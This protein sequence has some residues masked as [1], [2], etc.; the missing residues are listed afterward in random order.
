[1]DKRLRL[2]D[3]YRGLDSDPA[4]F[5]KWHAGRGVS[6][7]RGIC[8][9]EKRVTLC[10]S[11]E[12]KGRDGSNPTLSANQSV[13]FVYILEKA[14]NP[15]EMRRSFSSQ[16]TGESRTHAGFARFGDHSLRAK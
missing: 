9:K 15:R 2:Y 7:A 11:V 10:E 4:A 1:V 6:A 3:D 12:M 16:R 13:H 8:G 5:R 14:E